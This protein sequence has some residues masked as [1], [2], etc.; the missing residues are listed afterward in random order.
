M[1]IK[2]E[3]SQGSGLRTPFPVAERPKARVCGRS[4]AR[5]ADSNPTGGMNI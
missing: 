4:L 3:S 5:I 2:I 1:N